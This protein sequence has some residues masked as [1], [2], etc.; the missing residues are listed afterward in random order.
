MNR[1]KDSQ[2]LNLDAIGGNGEK[3]YQ[4]FACGEL[5]TYSD[6]VVAI[7]GRSRHFFVNPAGVECD[8][9]T[10]YA[11]RGAVTVG[12]P[13]LTDTWFPGFSWRMAFCRGCGQHLGWYYEAVSTA[14]WPSAFWG[15]LLSQ[16]TAKHATGS[17][18][19]NDFG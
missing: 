14:E 16:L 6:R 12:G 13:T 1:G 19:P 2:H 7:A 8:F 3:A 18:T 4:C 17:G 11:C 5:I 9:K 15:I 10:F